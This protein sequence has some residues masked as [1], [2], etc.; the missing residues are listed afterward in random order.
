M[1]N[2]NINTEVH[3]YGGKPYSEVTAAFLPSS[4][5]NTHSFVLV[6]S[7]RSPV[8]VCGTVPVLLCLEIFLG[9]VLCK[10]YMGEP[11]HLCSTWMSLL[12]QFPDLPRNHPRSTNRNPI[13]C[14]TYYP[15]S[16]HRT[17]KKSW[18]INH[19]S[20]TFGYRHLLR[21]D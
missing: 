17:E 16:F 4:L 7:T 6:F 5:G 20:I 19:V 11:T 10:I 1:V 9:S 3:H 8:L 21:T 13:I 12:R 2:Y 18:N 14:F 15:P